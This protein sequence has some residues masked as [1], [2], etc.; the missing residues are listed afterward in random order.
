MTSSRQSDGV[1]LNETIIDASDVILKFI[2]AIKDNTIIGNGLSI[3]PRKEENALLEESPGV[4]KG[5]EKL[6]DLEMHYDEEE[7]NKMSSRHSSLHTQHYY[8][9]L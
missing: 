7:D 8:Y 5:Y 4:C 1:D 9:L 3:K 2:L 6:G